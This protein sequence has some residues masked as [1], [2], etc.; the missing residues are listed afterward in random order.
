M[1]MIVCI[2]ETWTIKMVK[3]AYPQKLNPLK[4]SYLHEQLKSIL[5]SYM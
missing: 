3:V 1:G 2:G 4:I 5:N